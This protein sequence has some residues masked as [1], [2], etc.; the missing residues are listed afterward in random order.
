MSEEATR[1]FAYGTLRPGRAPAGLARQVAT[2]R[3]VAPARMR[4]VLYD[5]GTFP[6]AVH[7]PAA[8]GFVHGDVVELGP[9]SPPLA[10]FDLY[11][12]IHPAHPER[13]L[14]RRDW[15]AVETA[16]GRALECWVYV[17]QRVPPGVP[18][19]ASGEWTGPRR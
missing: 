2:L 17:L 19:I 3:S 4:G 11:E 18:R 6:G 12:E 14:Y 1:L 8:P 5:L 9:Q 16:D 15:I 7:E 10:F 13:S